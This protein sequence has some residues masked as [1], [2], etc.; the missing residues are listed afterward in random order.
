MLIRSTFRIFHVFQLYLLCILFA[1]K[2]LELI[3]YHF[4]LLS[5]LMVLILP[6]TFQN[7]ARLCTKVITEAFI[8][9]LRESSFTFRNRITTYS[10]SSTEHFFLSRW[11]VLGGYSGLRCFL[12]IVPP[13]LREPCTSPRL[14]IVRYEEHIH[15]VLYSALSVSLTAQV[16]YR[17]LVS[18]NLRLLAHYFSRFP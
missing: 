13:H 6:N 3:V 1:T 11:V 4:Y 18:H 9:T 17:A 14:F 2:L 8:L 10:L 5:R 15:L 16:T 12:F 7:A